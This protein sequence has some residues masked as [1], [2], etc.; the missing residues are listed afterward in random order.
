M[1]RFGFTD[2]DHLCACTRNPLPVRKAVSD[3]GEEI[4]EFLRV[5]IDSDGGMIK[6]FADEA[7]DIAY[8][9]GR[10][11][12]ALFGRVYFR[13]PGDKETL[14][15][16]KFRVLTSAC[17]RSLQ[18]RKKNECATA[19]KMR[20]QVRCSGCGK[21]FKPLHPFFS[22]DMFEAPCWTCAKITTHHLEVLP[23]KQCL[24][25]KG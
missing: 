25:C 20:V 5:P 2:L 9:T 16:I 18:H 17:I 15:K 6:A 8:A 23:E 10:L 11:I 13:V 12:G 1:K 22:Q 21:T 14:L 24:P 4:M 3:V 19:G 7:S